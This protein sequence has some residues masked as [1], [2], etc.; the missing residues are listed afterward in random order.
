MAETSAP[1]NGTATGDASIAPYDSSTEWAAYWR[2]L[3]TADAVPTNLG[4]V[5]AGA[6]NELAVTGTATPVSVASGRALAHGTWYES[7]AAVTVAIP[8]PGAATRIDRIVLRKD[9]A[10]QTVR[11]T[12]IAGVEGGG[13]PAL[14]Q[15]AATTWDTPL[16]Q[17]SITIGAVITV[18][19]ERE[20]L[21]WLATRRVIN[22]IIDETIISNAVLQND[23]EL[24]FAIKANEVWRFKAY[25]RFNSGTVPDIQFAFTVPAG[26]T[27][28]YGGY[29]NGPG[30]LAPKVVNASGG[31]YD[32]NGA[33]AI[34]NFAVIEGVVVNGAN[35]GNVQLQWAQYSSTASNTTVKKGSCILADRLAA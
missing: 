12:R 32:V 4:G 21:P 19:D 30:V 24:L 27:V 5:I 35:A 22:K 33:G 15:I 13:A 17:A 10:A 11:I 23:D 1:W 9:W 14:V 8:T 6:L 25:L 29:D 2:A 28:Q 16:A 7:S 34:D 26:A 31:F 20:F 3:S 18:T